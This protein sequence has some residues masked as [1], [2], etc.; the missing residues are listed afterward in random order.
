[1]S[2]KEL[3]NIVKQRHNHKLLCWRVFCDEICKTVKY[4]EYFKDFIKEKN[5][6]SI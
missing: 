1:M 3:R 2:Y 5:N 6:E 4:P